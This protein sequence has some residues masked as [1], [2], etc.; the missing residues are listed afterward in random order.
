MAKV[1]KDVRFCTSRKRKPNPVTV[2]LICPKCGKAWYRTIPDDIY[3]DEDEIWLLSQHTFCSL[4]CRRVSL[5]TVME[6]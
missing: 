2:S 5:D 1:T 4:K 3:L 6:D